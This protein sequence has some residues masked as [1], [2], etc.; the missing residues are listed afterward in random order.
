MNKSF[1]KVNK[2]LSFTLILLILLINIF[3]YAANAKSTIK[4]AIDPG[5]GGYDPGVVYKG[6]IEK[7]TTLDIS[8]RLK[9]CLIK[10]G[11]RVIMTRKSDKALWKLSNVGN[12]YKRR[13]L[14]ARA[15]IINNSGAKLFASIHVNSYIYHKKSNGSIVYY[16]PSSDKSKKLAESIQNSINNITIKGYKRHNNKATPANFYILK[17]T[18]IPGVLIETAFVSNSNE[19]KL[20]KSNKFKNKLVQAI[21]IGIKNSDTYKGQNIKANN[22][23]KNN[24]STKMPIIRKRNHK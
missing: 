22:H 4:I 18:K 14:N 1:N 20:L 16:Y 24:R 2:I 15:K 9:N 17:K 21:A 13:D 6:I 23:K 7:N 8:K 19:R 10:S 5:H 11:N 12:T 3:S